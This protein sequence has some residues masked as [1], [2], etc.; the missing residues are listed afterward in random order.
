MLRVVRQSAGPLMSGTLTDPTPDSYTSTSLAPTVSANTAGDRHE[1]Q[2]AAAVGYSLSCI[3]NSRPILLFLTNARDLERL[4][5]MPCGQAALD[6][7]LEVVANQFL[8]CIWCRTV[9]G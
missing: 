1:E 2:R 8:L 7:Y 4:Q 5:V 3:P 9:T 6:Q